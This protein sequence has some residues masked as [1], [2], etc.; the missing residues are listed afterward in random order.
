MLNLLDKNKINRNLKKICIFA[1]WK[2]VPI[3][4]WKD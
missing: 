1:I 2:H 3:S 4:M